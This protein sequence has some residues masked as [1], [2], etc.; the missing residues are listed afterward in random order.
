M[1]DGSVCVVRREEGQG[2]IQPQANYM[3][4]YYEVAYWLILRKHF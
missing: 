3:Y 4:I 1:Y 2:N